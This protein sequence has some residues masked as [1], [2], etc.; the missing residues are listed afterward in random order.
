M[1]RRD[2]LRAS[3]AG[4]ATLATPGIVRAEAQSVLKFIPQSD[5]ASLDPV[6]TTADVT[7]NHAHLV[8]DTLYGVDDNYQPHPQM[9][10]GHTTSADGLQWDITLRDGLRFHDNTPVLARD[11]VASLQRWGQV[12]GF[13]SV[14]MAATDEISAPSDKV[15]LFRLKKKFP[16]LPTALAAINRMACIMPERLAKTSPFQQVAEIIGSGPFRFVPSERVPG[17]RLVYEK[18]AGYVPTTA[19]PAQYT[20]GP[21]TAH[22]DRVVWT[23]SPDPA[24]NSAAMTAGEFDWWEQPT[25]DL[26]P[27]LKRD[28]HLTLVVKDRTGEIGCMRFNHLFP[29]FDNAAIRRVVVSAINQ[30]DYMEAVAGAA[31]ELIRDKV[32]LF[33]PGSPMASTVDLETM[34]GDKDV[35]KLKQALKDAGYKG[36]KVVVLAA[37]NY[38]TIN[39]IAEVGGDMLKRIGLNIDYQALD[40]GTVV[41]RRASRKPIDQGGW[42]IFFTFLGGMGNVSPASAI[43]LRADGHGWFGWPDDPKM[44]ALRKSWFDA[45]DLA[46]QQKVCADMQV[47]F[48]QNPSYAPLGMYFQPTCFNSSLQDVPN[49][50]PQFYRVHRV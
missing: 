28:K 8:F 12:D 4:A 14:L 46:A 25:I 6:W 7:R 39:A 26:V 37:S 19:G 42:N 13:G 23:V 3:L 36:E 31:P 29:P 44:E 35:T 2:I 38:P 5:L 16:L 22:F 30:R 41:Q 11:C 20:S 18:F 45:P 33:V 1:K 27:M 32:G 40:W 47:Q 49:G 50:I 34:H 48:F 10:A 17:S 21:K 43:P 9:A 15:V 24:T